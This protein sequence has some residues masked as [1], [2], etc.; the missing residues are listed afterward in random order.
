M[1]MVNRLYKRVEMHK[2]IDQL[3]RLVIEHKS[4]VARCGLLNTSDATD[5]EPTQLVNL[6]TKAEAAP[7]GKIRGT[8]HTM[9]DDSD[10]NATRHAR[11]AVGGARA[12]L[13]GQTALYV[14]DGAEHQGPAGG[15]PVCVIYRT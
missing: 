7:S 5:A 15:G 1:G 9:L 13:T 14:S 2:T 11:A 8:R 12:S 10:I 4:D 6:L 3:I